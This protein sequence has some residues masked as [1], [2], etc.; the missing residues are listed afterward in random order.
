MKRFPYRFRL[1]RLGAGLAL[2]AGL[3]LA[4]PAGAADT[5]PIAVAANLQDAMTEL[6]EAFEADTGLSVK[7]TFGSSG[8]FARQIR[9]GAPFE[10]FFSAD[11]AYVDDLADDGF[12]RDAGA[13][14]GVG[15]IVLI[16]PKGSPLAADGS[17]DD[18]AAALKDGRLKRFAIASP[19]HAPY[20]RAAEEAL[21]H[22]G[23]WDRLQSKL[24]LGE[25]V[26]Q[27]AQFAVSAN[28][29]GGIV[30]YSLALS[31]NVAARSDH[32]LI[33]ANWHAPLNQRMVLL[34]GAG[35]TA[36]RFHAYVQTPP[37]RAIFR[38]YG[39]LLPDETD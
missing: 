36:E 6:V 33:P 27:A 12:T 32:A 9:Q 5:P 38:K 13:L 17:L 31:P 3:A 18:L 30:A 1:Q 34:N 25:N 14:Y 8:N 15:R 16:L 28:A 4:G 10:L 23:L 20:G 29:Q 19:A 11:E 35:E 24:V 21:G 7:P 26:S 22:K 39:Y 2:L 37:A